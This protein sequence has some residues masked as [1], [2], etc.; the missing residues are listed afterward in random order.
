MGNLTCLEQKGSGVTLYYGWW[1]E[2]D[3]S[4]LCSWE[5][6][7][8]KRTSTSYR[9]NWHHFILQLYWASQVVI[10]VKNPLA[11]AE[12]KRDMGSILGSGRYPG[13]GNGNPLLY[14]CLEN[15]MNRVAWQAI[16]HGVAKGQTHLKWLSTMHDIWL[17]HWLTGK[18]EEPGPPSPSG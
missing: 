7:G 4:S 13:G 16:V 8:S 14:S 9:R 1:A 10:V 5:N 11:N 15:L 3:S 6:G 17:A 18:P 2:E 12:N